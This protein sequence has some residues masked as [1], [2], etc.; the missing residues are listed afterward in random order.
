METLLPARQDAAP[1]VQPRLLLRVRT[2]VRG[3]RAG[4]RGGRVRGHSHSGAVRGDGQIDGVRKLC[5]G[6]CGVHIP[7]GRTCQRGNN[8]G[9]RN[10]LPDSVVFV[11]A[12]VPAR[13][14]AD[15]HTHGH[16]ARWRTK[17]Q[18]VTSV[19]LPARGTILGRT[20]LRGFTRAF[21]LECAC[22]GGACRR[23]GT[24]R[25]ACT[26]PRALTLWR[27]QG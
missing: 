21:S 17:S 22:E 7:V 24:P 12:H 2:G 9:A 18:H 23:G 13:P 20:Q 27:R 14:W 6:P 10:D 4:G 26:R 25:E 19:P 11:I 3:M 16:P 15:A 5:A 1:R 8:S